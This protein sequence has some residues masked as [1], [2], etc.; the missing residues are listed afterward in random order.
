MK[1]A[2]SCLLSVSMAALHLAVKSLA[3][4]S[5]SAGPKPGTGCSA[6]AL[7]WEARACMCEDGKTVQGSVTIGILNPRY[8]QTSMSD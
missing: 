1:H 7:L 6:A 5:A 4:G 3:I 8:D 2:A